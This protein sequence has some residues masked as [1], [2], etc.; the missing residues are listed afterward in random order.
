MRILHELE[1]GQQ[2]YGSNPEVYQVTGYRRVR[3]PGE[4]PAKSLRD[5]RVPLGQA[6][7]V[8][9]V[10]HSLVERGSGRFVFGA[11]KVTGRD[12]ATRHVRSRISAV[13]TPG[14]VEMMTENPFT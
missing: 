12:H 1:D 13:V 8:G 7:H 10:D 6:L 4:G 3:Y 11:V 5:F 2:L 14:V 9:L